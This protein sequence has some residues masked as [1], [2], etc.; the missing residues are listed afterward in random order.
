MALFKNDKKNT[1]KKK[2]D[3]VSEE[4]SMKDLY[5]EE[6]K[7]KNVKKEDGKNDKKARKSYEHSYR[8]LIKPLITEKSS[9]LSAK[10]AYC[11]EVAISTNKI[12]VA[13]AIEEVYGVKP[14]KVNVINIEGKRKTRGRVKGKRKDW[15][16]AFVFLP[17]GKT[18]DVYEGV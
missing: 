16:K 7:A 18:I 15:K 12:E 6:N 5:S 11:F 1:T 4:A 10:G 17:K 9:N 14:E 3:E 13:K 2:T 8:V